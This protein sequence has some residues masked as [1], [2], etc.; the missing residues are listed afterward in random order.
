[1]Y[2]EEARALLHCAQDGENGVAV[3]LEKAV[4]V[5]HRVPQERVHKE[6]AI[7][8]A[9]RQYLSSTLAAN[10]NVDNRAQCDRC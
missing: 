10:K 4:Q 2:L 8:D 7:A 3:V 1:M 5:R 6:A 9:Q